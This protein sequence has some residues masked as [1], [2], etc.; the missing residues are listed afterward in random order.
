MPTQVYLQTYGCQMNERDSE[1]IL[2]MLTAQGYAV[3]PREEDADVILLNTCSVREHAEE[4][5]FGKMAAMQHLK[6][7]KPELVLGILGCMAKAQREEVFRRLPQVDLVAGPAEIYDLP[8]LLAQVAERRQRDGLGPALPERGPLPASRTQLLA[9][10]RRVRPLD[11]KPAG[12]YRRGRVTAFVTIMEGCDKNCAY[13]I[14]PTTRGQEVSRPLAEILE[15]VQQ[16]ARAEY[17]QVTLLGQNVNSYGKRFPDGSGYL[18]PGRRRQLLARP[19]EA[20]PGVENGPRLIDFPVLLRQIDAKT[21][22]ERVKFT[23]SHP[24]DAHEELFRAMADCR[25]VCEFLHLPVQ[26]GSD[27]VLKGMRRGYTVA[28]YEARVARLREL[29]P[30]VVLSTD[31]IAGFPG[32][33]DEDFEATRALMERIEYDGAFIFKYSPRPGT[34]AARGVDDVPRAVKERRHQELLA[35]QE[36]ISRRKLARWV[37]REVEVLLEERN[38]RGQ[39]AGHTRGNLNVVCDGPDARIG[40]LALVRVR[41]TTATTLISE[42]FG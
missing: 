3:V 11:R 24:F 6:R 25:A 33:T 35:V 34:D 1:E 7:Q 23:T 32:E 15:E 31:I 2:G 20:E 39:L 37:G 40:E 41:E 27:R 18:G 14:V 16:L 36:R 30:D 4:R 29:V 26:S 9:I 42:L 12:D 19:A 8:D 28:A 21:S 38:R 22:I 13:C 17:K 10:D 5:A